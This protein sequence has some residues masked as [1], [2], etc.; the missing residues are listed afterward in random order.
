VQSFL[1]HGDV[2]WCRGLAMISIDRMAEIFRTTLAAA[3]KEQ[4]RDYEAVRFVLVNHGVFRATV[5]CIY[6][7]DARGLLTGED[8]AADTATIAAFL[9][10]HRSCSASAFKRGLAGLMDRAQQ[11]LVSRIDAQEAPA[12]LFREIMKEATGRELG[13]DGY[14]NWLQRATDEELDDAMDTFA[15]H[16]KVHVDAIVAACGRLTDDEGRVFRKP[17]ISAALEEALGP[18]CQSIHDERRRRRIARTGRG[19]VWDDQ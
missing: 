5:D 8:E 4:S 7:H 3:Q 15:K 18:A 12:R 11:K 10:D 17:A 1:G 6:H 19:S 13:L 14:L 16:S 9:R 2:S